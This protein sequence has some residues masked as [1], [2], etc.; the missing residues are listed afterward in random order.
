VVK[1]DLENQRSRR[2]W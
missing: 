1:F 2:T